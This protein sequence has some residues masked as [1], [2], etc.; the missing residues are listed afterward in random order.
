MSNL[1][2]Y[3]S[4]DLA[5]V[6]ET[7]RIR[8]SPFADLNDPFE[9]LPDTRLVEDPIWQRK[10]EDQCTAEATFAAALQSAKTGCTVRFSEHAYRTSFRQRYGS[11]TAELKK[12][13]IRVFADEARSPFRILCLSR[14]A[15]GTGEAALMWGHYTKE[16]SGFVLEFDGA[17]DWV[18]W[19]KRENGPARDMGPVIYEHHRPTWDFSTE[20]ETRP[21]SD[22]VMTKSSHWAY[23]QE[24][25]LIRFTGTDG[26]DASKVDSLVSF[27]PDLLR[28]VTFGVNT[29]DDTKARIRAACARSELSHVKIRQAEIH[30]DEYRLL[31][32]DEPAAD[33]A[34]G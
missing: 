18:Q 11:R 28:S 7:L 14:Q 31:V 1:F 8:F 24:Y 34:H 12:V 2:K 6:V 29:Q 21:R 17:H 19:H 13:A 4:P 32:V 20:G 25:R 16:H 3:C 23:E 10:L 22:F 5:I 15:P 33:A 9:S 26:L 27:P 30:P